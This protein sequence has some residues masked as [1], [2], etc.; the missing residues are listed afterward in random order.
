MPGMPIRIRPIPV[1]SWW[2]RH[3]EGIV[4]DDIDAAPDDG[5]D[6][7]LIPEHLDCLLCGPSRYPVGLCQTVDR[8]Q[9]TA[10]RK[11]AALYLISENRGKLQVDRYVPLVIDR[12]TGDFR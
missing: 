10:R 1:L 6:Q 5:P 8:W 9:R 7:T 3:L 4:R 12:H 11:L 2:S